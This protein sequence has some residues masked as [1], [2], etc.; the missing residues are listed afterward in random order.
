MAGVREIRGKL[1]LE[2]WDRARRQ[3]MKRR[4]RG[5]RRAG[6]RT[7][8]ELQV[9][10]DLTSLGLQTQVTN[11][12]ELKPLIKAWQAHLSGR[13]RP[14]TW[15]GYEIGLRMILTWMERKGLRP[16]LVS[17]LSLDAVEAWKQE[18]IQR[19]VPPKLRPLAPATVQRR[20][21]A[22]VALLNWAKRSGRIA[23]NP[24]S[25]WE[26]PRGPQR[27]ERRPFSSWDMAKLLASSPPCL[28]DIWQAFVHTGLR[29]GELRALE[30]D[31]V[32][33]DAQQIRVRGETS[34]SKRTRFV[35]MSKT[36]SL[37]LQRL[38]LHVPDRPDSEPCR[39]LVFVNSRENGWSRG[40][41][42]TS[43]KRCLAA[44]GTRR[45]DL[46][47]FRHTFA[48]E[49]I[50]RGCDVRTLQALLGHASA[51]TTLEHYAHLFRDRAHE[52][53]ALLEGFGSPDAG[54]ERMTS[55][56]GS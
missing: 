1:Y 52:V 32:D 6:Q 46:H 31:D 2:W 41:L 22:L 26:P 7:A 38:R 24:L 9:A 54:T 28:A 45:A 11:D 40:S 55:A 13:T 8:R 19:G 43:L 35:P 18:A 12:V 47:T 51:R 16:R 42:L 48:S 37:V 20:V 4:W 15:E 49:L 21:G 56:T 33:F 3:T 44:A 39:R 14:R 17:D 5:T 23:S 34:K 50:R 10:A 27:R 29:S 25:G 36:V 30:W 53:V